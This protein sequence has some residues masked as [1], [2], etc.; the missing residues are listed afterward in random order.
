MRAKNTDLKI[1]EGDVIFMLKDLYNSLQLQVSTKINSSK[2]NI[3]NTVVIG[4][5]FIKA[6]IETGGDCFTN[7]NILVIIF[8]SFVYGYQ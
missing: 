2:P 3:V 7:W 5:I 4:R 6:K 8:L 1:I